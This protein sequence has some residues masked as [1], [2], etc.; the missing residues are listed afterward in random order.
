ML[1]GCRSEE[2]K[3]DSKLERRRWTE[4]RLLSFSG[5]GR[6]PWALLPFFFLLS[7]CFYLLRSFHHPCCLSLPPSLSETTSKWSPLANQPAAKICTTAF[8]F[9]L[10]LHACVIFQVF[11][12]VCPSWTFWVDPT[13]SN[14][15]AHTNSDQASS[16]VVFKNPLHSPWGTEALCTRRC[17]LCVECIHKLA[18]LPL[19]QLYLQCFR[20]A[21]VFLPCTGIFC[22]EVYGNAT[23]QQHSHCLIIQPLSDFNR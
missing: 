8:L 5:E 1:W 9:S 13:Q 19:F 16:R 6:N 14:T 18:S 2:V 23:S 15:H 4:D 20:R 3:D 22:E 12:R 17:C 21:V 7:H 11:E 10:C